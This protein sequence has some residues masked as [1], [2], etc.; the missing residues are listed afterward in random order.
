MIAVRDSVELY[1]REFDIDGGVR[2]RG[3][4]LLVH[5]FSWHSAYFQQFARILNEQ[6]M[7]IAIHM[8][9]LLE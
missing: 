3:T 4:V 2:L 8:G 7:Y 9:L 6:G 5:G 1:V